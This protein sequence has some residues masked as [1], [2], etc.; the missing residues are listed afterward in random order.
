M[1]NLHDYRLRCI[2]FSRQ[3]VTS[4]TAGISAEGHR[5][6]E[7]RWANVEP[8]NKPFI[9]LSFAFNRFVREVVSSNYLDWEAM[10]LQKT[11]F[12]RATSLLER[13]NW[14]SYDMQ[15]FMVNWEKIILTEDVLNNDYPTLLILEKQ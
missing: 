14:H 7:E 4:W 12:F 13:T 9:L 1:K 2:S 6:L 15:E 10:G 11:V 8:L 3:S 5:N